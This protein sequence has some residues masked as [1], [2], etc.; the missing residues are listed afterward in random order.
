MGLA[1]FI[2]RLVARQRPHQ[3]VDV[4]GDAD[5]VDSPFADGKVGDH[6]GSALQGEDH[7]GHDQ[8]D[9]EDEGHH[10]HGGILIFHDAGYQKAQHVGAVD[11]QKEGDHQFQQRRE[12]DARLREMIPVGKVHDQCDDH[13]LHQADH[14]LIDHMGDHIGGDVQT[15]AVFPLDDGPLPAD[16]LDGIED[17]HPDAGA[18][19]GEGAVSGVLRRHEGILPG[20]RGNDQ[21]DDG[22]AD[23]HLPSFFVPEHPE[24]FAYID[25]DLSKSGN[26]RSPHR[27]PP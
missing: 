16:G 2:I 21:C 9:D 13:R 19:Q 27:N 7:T 12:E 25:L 20:H 4:G 17:A 26:S 1:E 3:T 14:Q 8:L 11:D 6:L 18:H 23:Q 5:G 24:A 15:G 22:G 10:R